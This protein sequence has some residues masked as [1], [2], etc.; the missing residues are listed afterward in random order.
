VLLPTGEQRAALKRAE[1]TAFQISWLAA[2]SVAVT[3]TLGWARSRD[4]ARDGDP[5]LS[6]FTYDIGAELRGEP[7]A[8]G[9]I[10]LSPF[11]GLGAGG[12]SYD[13][14]GF[15]APA[16]H[17]AAAYAAIGGELG[18]R[19]VRLRIEARDYVTRF[20]PLSGRGQGDS[21]NDIMMMAGLR[22]VWRCA[23]GRSH[24]CSAR[25]GALRRC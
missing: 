14:R 18:Y 3:T 6:V 20:T 15:D 1:L 23:L 22:F 16:K 10:S 12:R 21:R 9:R 4:V 25:R 5:R 2:H 19:R 13:Y 24:S 11:A 8:V 17:H 7:Q